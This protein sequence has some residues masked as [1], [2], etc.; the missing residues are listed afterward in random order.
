M[1]RFKVEEKPNYI[2]GGAIAL[3]GLLVCWLI[4]GA[5]PARIHGLLLGAIVGGFGVAAA[6]RIWPGL[7]LGKVHIYG[8]SMAAYGAVCALAAGI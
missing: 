6:G 7:P 2:L 1:S 5:L 4:V 3:A 8:L